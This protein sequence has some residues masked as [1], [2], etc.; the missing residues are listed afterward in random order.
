V[1]KATLTAFAS[2]SGQSDPLATPFAEPQGMPP[3]A[4]C[5]PN[6]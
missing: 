6:F 4:L 2:L 5:R 3:N 1:Q